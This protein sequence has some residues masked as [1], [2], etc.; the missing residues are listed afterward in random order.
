MKLS[1]LKA[2]LSEL[3]ELQFVLPNGELVPSHFHITEIGQINKKY[4]DCGGELRE[5][6]TINF[7]LWENTDTHHRLEP[8]KLLKIIDQAESELILQD[9]DIEVEYQGETI[10]K[11]H[12]SMENGVFQLISTKT[13]C[14]AEDQC[15][16]PSEKTKVNFSDISVSNNCTPGSGCC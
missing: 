5:E 6:N 4:M 7:Q 2:T 10:G 12:L 14:L 13:A 15:I 11:Y 9:L 1:Q 16:A 3:N 8:Q